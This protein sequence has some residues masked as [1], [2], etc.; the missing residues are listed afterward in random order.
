MQTS[1]S[2]ARA[3]FERV[4][5][6]FNTNVRNEF[7]R[8]IALAE[9]GERALSLFHDEGISGP[10]AATKPRAATAPAPKK[11]PGKRGR[12]PKKVVAAK[13]GRPPA[14]DGPTLKSAL[15]GVL[16][17]ATKPMSVQEIT[18][19]IVAAGYKSSS[20]NLSVIVGNNLIGMKNE[21]RRVGR[22]V[23]ELVKK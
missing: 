3:A 1:T 23:Y 20:K 6:Q 21:I 10:R 7:E 17:S 5:E 2:G 15:L 12:P 18:A 11:Q 22:G 14:K 9:V 4:L 8:L 16:S 19:G 13:P